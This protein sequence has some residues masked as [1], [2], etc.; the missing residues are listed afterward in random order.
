MILYFVWM[1]QFF[2]LLALEQN[3]FIFK[4]AHNK[5]NNS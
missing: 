5:H 2:A 3:N 4:F 1:I